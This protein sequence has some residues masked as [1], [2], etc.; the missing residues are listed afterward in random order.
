MSYKAGIYF[1]CISLETAVFFKWMNMFNMI[2]AYHYKRGFY[3][4]N[5]GDFFFLK[6][7]FTAC[8][9]DLVCDL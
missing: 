7:S 5:S 6:A 4:Y 1:E 8:R 2:R 9:A 3:A